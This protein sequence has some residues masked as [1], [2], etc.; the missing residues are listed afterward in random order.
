MTGLAASTAYT[1]TV[2]ARNAVGSGAGRSASAT[3][4]AA[5]TAP[6]APTAVDATASGSAVTVTWGAPTVDGGSPL[7]GFL[8][9]GTDGSSREVGPAGQGHDLLRRR[10]RH[11]HVHGPR[12]QRRR[13]GSGAG[14]SVTVQAAPGVPQGVAA[15]RDASGSALTLR[16]SPP[17]TGGAV[18]GYRVTLDGRRADHAPGEHPQHGLLPRLDRGAHPD[19][20]R[21]RC[22][23]AR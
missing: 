19:G 17:V 4:Q 20:P 6:G 9:E 10:G 23:R 22:R 5:P 12:P 13:A 21:G 8:V 3:T 16:W 15:T 18:T 14:H 1:F 2:A 7:T 11:P